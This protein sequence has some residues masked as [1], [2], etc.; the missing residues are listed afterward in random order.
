MEDG[1]ETVTKAPVDVCEPAQVILQIPGPVLRLLLYCLV[2]R[3]ANYIFPGIFAAPERFIA[4]AGSLITKN[5]LKGGTSPREE[6][7]PHDSSLTTKNYL[8]GKYYSAAPADFVSSYWSQKT[9]NSLPGQYQFRIL[10]KNV[11][12]G[13]VDT[14]RTL[15][16]QNMPVTLEYD[17]D[18]SYDIDRGYVG[19]EG[20]VSSGEEICTKVQPKETSWFDLMDM[21]PP[22]CEKAHGLLED[23]ITLKN[24][25]DED[26][27]DEGLS[28]VAN[29]E[30]TCVTEQLKVTTWFRFMDLP[31]VIRWMVYQ[32]ILVNPIL[33]QHVSVDRDSDAGTTSQYG[34]CP[35]VLR[36]NRDVYDEA[37]RVL[38][39]ENTFCFV[40]VRHWHYTSRWIHREG[41]YNCKGLPNWSEEK[42]RVEGI[43]PLL[44]YQYE[45]ATPLWE[46][47]QMKR[48]KRW[49]VLVVSEHRDHRLPDFSTRIDWQNT[50]QPLRQFVRVVA[51][52]KS[53]KLEILV[54]N[55][56][57]RGVKR[58]MEDILAP[59][60]FLRDI[61]RLC[62]RN[63]LPGEFPDYYLD[64]S[65]EELITCGYKKELSRCVDI[66]IKEKNVLRPFSKA[67]VSP[68]RVSMGSLVSKISSSFLT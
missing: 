48:V 34:L 14:F 59:L 2:I 22:I 37:S 65:V 30:K 27:S 46:L 61:E 35:A 7:I 1:R 6:F 21:P 67:G 40:C 33:G 66:E 8:P 32:L 24:T 43:S 39:N 10:L 31:S 47:P 23:S 18:P 36:L 42:I 68:T 25:S 13:C 54:L 52:Q 56:P 60:Q 64:S 4:Q 41:D 9:K 15:H 28:D 11:Y 38:Y 29:G 55:K 49:R 44:R 45:R 20:Y 19:D 12:V 57:S 17:R 58:A 53:R 16:N 3:I 5:Y 62:V 26:L 50:S 51:R 63:A